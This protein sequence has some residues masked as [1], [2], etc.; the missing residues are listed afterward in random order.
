MPAHRDQLLRCVMAVAR[1][2]DS[3]VRA[4]AISNLGEVCRLLHFSLG[5]VLHEVS[6]AKF[7]WLRLKEVYS[8]TENVSLGSSKSPHSLPLLH[9][10]WID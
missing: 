7:F 8:S 10:F 5:P 6:L 2:S 1:S 4:S 3:Q 9:P